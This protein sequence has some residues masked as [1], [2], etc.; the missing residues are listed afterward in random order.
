VKPAYFVVNPDKLAL[1]RFPFYL[2]GK[3][4]GEVVCGDFRLIFFNLA[5]L[6]SLSKK[7]TARYG[8]EPNC[9]KKPILD[10]SLSFRFPI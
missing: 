4:P 6:L 10:A 1:Y 2:Q 9:R 8:S 7:R 3:T 5:Y